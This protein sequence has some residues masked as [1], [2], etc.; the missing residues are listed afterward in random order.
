MAATSTTRAPSLEVEEKVGA[1]AHSYDGAS[2]QGQTANLDKLEPEIAA[3]IATLTP[4]RRAEIEKKLKL[5]IDLILFPMLLIF[6]ILNYIVKTTRGVLRS[7][8]I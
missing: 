4:E 5:K 2:N 8:T 3:I 7:R 1:K 6:Y